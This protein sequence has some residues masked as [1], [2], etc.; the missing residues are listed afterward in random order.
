MGAEGPLGDHQCLVGRCASTATTD[1][2]S[3][4]YAYLSG[5]LSATESRE[6]S[7]CRYPSHQSK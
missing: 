1:D 2:D 4:S 3:L 6:G 5:C 7:K